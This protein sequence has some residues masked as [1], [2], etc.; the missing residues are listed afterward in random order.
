MAISL[1]S[2]S[3]CTTHIHTETKKKKPQSSY[4]QLLLF[5]QKSHFGL[6]VKMKPIENIQEFRSL[7]AWNILFVY[8]LYADYKRAGPR[9]LWP[10]Q[11]P[12]NAEVIFYDPGFLAKLRSC[13]FVTS[14]M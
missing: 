14:Y 8:S 4:D 1:P 12:S 10:D 2:N 7:S 5:T 3:N 9:N 11:G 13:R 6:E